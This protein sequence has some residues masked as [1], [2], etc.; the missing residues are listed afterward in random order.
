M[1]IFNLM[2]GLMVMMTQQQVSLHFNCTKNINIIASLKS[3]PS[4]WFNNFRLMRQS[5]N[6]L[7]FSDSKVRRFW[8][9]VNALIG[10]RHNL[11]VRACFG[12]VGSYVRSNNQ[13][14]HVRFKVENNKSMELVYSFYYSH[15]LK[16]M[17]DAITAISAI[18][19]S[20][21]QL[22]YDRLDIAI[23]SQVENKY[24]L[25]AQSVREIISG[26]PNLEVANIHLIDTMSD[27][28]LGKPTGRIMTQEEEANVSHGRDHYHT[29]RLYHLILTPDII[30]AITDVLK[31]ENSVVKCQESALDLDENLTTTLDFKN[32]NIDYLDLKIWDDR[33]I[34]FKFFG[35]CIYLKFELSSSG[36]VI[37][38]K[39]E[40]NP[41]YNEGSQ[42]QQQMYRFVKVPVNDF[43][44]YRLNISRNAAFITIKCGSI[45]QFT[46]GSSTD[47]GFHDYSFDLFPT[48]SSND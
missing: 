42:S 29:A 28:I 14:N 44:T 37:C 36:S 9:Y 48:A 13:D 17:E 45:Q 19:N 31:P 35:C 23:A 30:N 20:G 26:C 22:F 11:R 21:P 40:D 3:W 33:N 16:K 10:A 7:P 25:V 32:L 5:E 38:Y 24:L 15:I 4:V 41:Q 27:L 39:S 8:E 47:F 34:F 18:P 6:I 1:K 43:D 2:S 46:L 12:I